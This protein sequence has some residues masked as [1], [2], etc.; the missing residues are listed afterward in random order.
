M[1]FLREWARNLASLVVMLGLIELLLPQDSLRPYVRMVLGLLVIVALIRPVL[2][3]L[4]GLKAWEPALRS[5]SESGVEQ[6]IETGDRIRERGGA[7]AGE[8]VR[9][10][11]D[12]A[13]FIK[14]RVPGLIIRRVRRDGGRMQIW[15]AHETRPESEEETIRLLTDLGWDKNLI[16][17]R[18]D[19]R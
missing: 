19:A 2:H 14:R 6:A 12:W 13:E 5:A 18:R 1:E 17:V 4:P 16:E 11:I 15:V 8:V 10:D 3:E 7:A 9:G